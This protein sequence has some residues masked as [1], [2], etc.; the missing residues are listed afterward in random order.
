VGGGLSAPISYSIVKPKPRIGN[1]IDVSSAACIPLLG[2]LNQPF[3]DR[4]LFNVTGDELEGCAN[5]RLTSQKSGHQGPSHI[6]DHRSKSADDFLQA[7]S[8]LAQRADLDGL[9]Q[10]RK[11]ILP[12]LN[13]SREFIERSLRFFG[14]FLFEFRQPVDL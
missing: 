8:Y 6:S 4:I 14:V 9:E 1:E 3:R 12:A 11:T 10:F 2:R 7:A 13:H 5:E